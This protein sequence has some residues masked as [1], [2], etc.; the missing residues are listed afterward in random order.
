MATPVSVKQ[1]LSVFGAIAVLGAL[2]IAGSVI[3]RGALSVG[4]AI[5]APSI[6]VTSTG[7]S[8]NSSGTIFTVGLKT[9]GN[10]TST[11]NIYPASNN[12]ADIGGSAAAFKDVY[13]SGTSRLGALSND[14]NTT[15]G[16]SS[17]D[18]LTLNAQ[19]ASSITPS[20]NNARAIGAFGNAWSSLF[21]SGTIKIGGSAATSSIDMSGGTGAG[22]GSCIKMTDSATA[23][24]LYLYVAGG[25]F[26]TSTTSC[27]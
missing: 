2:T 24:A 14:G 13:S 5:T 3:F 20:T 12:A 18:T 23:A 26:V 1:G 11:G 10:V 25:Q 22:K 6:T 4:G 17:A 7:F 27:L 19:I 21:A 9:T 15:L 8:V 16:D